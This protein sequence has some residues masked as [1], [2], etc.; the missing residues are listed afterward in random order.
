MDVKNLKFVKYLIK[1]VCMLVTI[2]FVGHWLHRY[3]LDE[4]SS[5]I[6]VREYFDGADD[7]F[8]VMSLCFK[9]TFQ[10]LQ[11]KYPDKNLSEFNYNNILIGK[12]YHPLVTEIDYHSV[13]TN[14]SDFIL[15]YDVEFRNGTSFTATL[16][17]IAWK[18]PYYT[19]TWDSWGRIVKC[20][21]LEI[22]EK[23]VYYVRL[24][25]KREIFP[26]MTRNSNGG[27]AVLF[28]YPN[29]VLAS[30][31]T[32]RRQWMKRDASTNFYMSFNL[33]GM[34]VHIQ[35]H[36]K[37]R[38]NCVE[39]WKNYD[40]II[41][42][43]HLRR[44]GCKTPDQIANDTLSV[45]NTKEKMKE[46]RLHLNRLRL[47]PCREIVSIDSDMGESDSTT[48]K[49]WKN[50]ISFVFRIL[51]PSF[52]VTKQRK[53]VDLQTLIG[54]IGGYIGIFTGFAIAQIPDYMY[55]ALMSF[56]SLI[57]DYRDKKENKISGI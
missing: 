39:N 37:N 4:D 32:V 16:R 28:H 48:K 14:I 8:P 57:F 23:E 47:R 15:G 11:S 6:E 46:A 45:C 20:F 54:Y 31:K 17:N 18:P 50:W 42:A 44:V 34:G 24:F 2:I 52:T 30:I 36:R 1:V 53:D 38:H 49:L 29:Q 40:S 13:S 7:V 55:V 43:N 21:G 27:F 19:T 9:Q 56:K 35:R 3:M 5:V 25:V 33:K 41:M 51:N 12:Q 22:T 10:A 26:N